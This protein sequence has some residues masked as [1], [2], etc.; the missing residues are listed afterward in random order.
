MSGKQDPLDLILCTR[1]KNRKFIRLNIRNSRA[2]NNMRCY[3]GFQSIYFS[4]AL[5]AL[6]LG[7]ALYSL[8]FITYI[9]VFTPNLME[10]LG[11]VACL[12]YTGINACI[13][14]ESML[15]Y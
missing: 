5:I 14:L 11:N 9:H 4:L 13:Y 15:Y 8:K 10:K 1:F 3:I 6:K 12:P 2:H 7:Q